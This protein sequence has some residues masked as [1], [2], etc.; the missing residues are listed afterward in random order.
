MGF[1]PLPV[2]ILPK[3]S[4][5]PPRPNHELQPPMVIDLK[6]KKGRHHFC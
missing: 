6:K 2:P 5:P 1:E 4:N 3:L